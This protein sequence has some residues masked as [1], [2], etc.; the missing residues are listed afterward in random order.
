[1]LTPEATWMS[2]VHVSIHYKKQ[3]SF[4]SIVLVTADSQ[5]IMRDVEIF[6]DSFSILPA[7]YPKKRKRKKKK[8]SA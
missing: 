7:L 6:C 5:L 4:F 1:M 2:M 3:G 8:E